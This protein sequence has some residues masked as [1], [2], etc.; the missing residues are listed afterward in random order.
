MPLSGVDRSS[1]PGDNVIDLFLHQSNVKWFGFYLGPAPS[2]S[3]HSWM[4]RRAHLVGLGFGLAPI[5][6]GQQEPNIPHSSHVLTTAQGMADGAGAVSL[7][8][9]AGFPSSSVIYLDIESG[10]PLSSTMLTYTTAWVG[11]V[12]AG[13]F[14]TGIYCSHNVS[15]ALAVKFPGTFIWNWKIPAHSPPYHAPFPVPDPANSGYTG[16][17][18]WQFAQNVNLFVG[19][20]QLLTYDLDSSTV[21]DPSMPQ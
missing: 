6:V 1:Y 5:Y 2:H 17:T 18:M 10:G 15:A 21:Q 13:N 8:A 19:G 11:A 9:G 16:A 12:T 4:S 14:R 7:A 20:T 3:D